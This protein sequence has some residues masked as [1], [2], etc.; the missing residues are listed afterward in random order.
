MKARLDDVGNLPIPMMSAELG[1]LMGEETR[2]AG[3]KPD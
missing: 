1:K 3:I 2:A